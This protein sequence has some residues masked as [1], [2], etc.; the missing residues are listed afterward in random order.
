MY[1]EI[2]ASIHRT[3]RPRIPG[4]NNLLTEIAYKRLPNYR[5]SIRFHFTFLY[6]KPQ[7]HIDPSHNSWFDL[8][9]TISLIINDC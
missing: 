4:D 2:K 1:F 8:H 7:L 9:V 6:V 5:S 3:I